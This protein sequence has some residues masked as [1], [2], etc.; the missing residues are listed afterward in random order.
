MRIS[1]QEF[2]ALLMKAFELSQWRQAACVGT[3]E[4]SDRNPNNCEDLAESQVPSHHKL[5][6][7]IPWGPDPNEL[8]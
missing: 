2:E 3:E 5:K 6:N 7:R 1:I 8:L 4:L